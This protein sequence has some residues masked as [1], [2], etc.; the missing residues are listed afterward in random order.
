M[1]SIKHSIDG[2]AVLD[3]LFQDLVRDGYAVVKGV[4]P[5]EKA[6]AYADEIKQWLEDFGLGY[7]RDDP[8]T[9]REECLPIIPSKGLLQAYGAT[10]ES[11]T[12]GVRS[13]PGV[14]EAFET[15]YQ[16]KDL[17]CSFDAVNIS[18]ARNDLG[19]NTAWPHQDQGKRFHFF[20]CNS[21]QL[22]CTASRSGTW[23][24]SLR[25][26]ARQSPAERP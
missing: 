22:I 16:D 11:F 10:H 13:E 14:I 8:S 25:A 18:L 17:I 23:W 9:I 20:I 24:P 3:S 19:E 12:W 21:C 26:R 15:L 2:R 7:K 4:V 5:Q 1:V 6:F